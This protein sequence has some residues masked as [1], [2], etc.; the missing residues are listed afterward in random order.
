AML[1]R[2]KEAVAAASCAIELAP[3]HAGAHYTRAVYR[4]HL[5]EDDPGV[6]ADLD[7]MVE[8]APREVLYLEKHAEHLLAS[9]EYDGALADVDRA[10]ALAPD[11]ARLRAL[12]RKCLK[13]GALP[14]GTR[15]RK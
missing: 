5:D 1:G 15:R 6:R 14:P 11:N 8:L 2:M 9:E 10:L 12:R 4:S 3:D 13:G 7:R